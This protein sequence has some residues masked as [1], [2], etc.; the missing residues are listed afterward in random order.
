MVHVINTTL[1]QLDDAEEARHHPNKH[2]VLG[3]L[4]RAAALSQNRRPVDD[5]GRGR[6]RP[7]DIE[8]TFFCWLGLTVS[9]CRVP[10]GRRAAT[11]AV[12]DA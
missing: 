7:D 8:I 2:R 1:Q 10:T 6:D 3:L 9:L 11:R 5:D 12:S 4:R